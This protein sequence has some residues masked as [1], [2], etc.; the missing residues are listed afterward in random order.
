ML[1][2]RERISFFATRDEKAFLLLHVSHPCDVSRTYEGDEGLLVGGV[3]G[4]GGAESSGDSKRKSPSVEKISS[5][6][7]ITVGENIFVSISFFFLLDA[8]LWELLLLELLLY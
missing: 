2:N 7:A 6:A 4:D 3:D 5:K 1:Q 8:L